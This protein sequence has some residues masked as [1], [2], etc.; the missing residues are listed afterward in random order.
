MTVSGLSVNTSLET[1]GNT[2][3][4]KKKSSI[5]VFPYRGS[6]ESVGMLKARA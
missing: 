4:R 6:L 1:N 3:L 2:F 5:V